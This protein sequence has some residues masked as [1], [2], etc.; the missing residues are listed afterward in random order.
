V[1]PQGQRQ[2]CQVE[3]DQDG[4]DKVQA[5]RIGQGTED[6]ASSPPMLMAWSI[7]TPDE[8]PTRVGMS[9]AG[10]G[11]EGDLVPRALAA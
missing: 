4:D 2:P 3:R 1:Q 9:L 5:G 6:G 8:V 7:V 11:L 10:A